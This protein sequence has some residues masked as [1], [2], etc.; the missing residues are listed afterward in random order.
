MNNQPASS[1]GLNPEDIWKLPAAALLE[2]LA[3]SAAGLAGAEVQLRLALYGP[4]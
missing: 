1:S 4:N 3:T 2:R